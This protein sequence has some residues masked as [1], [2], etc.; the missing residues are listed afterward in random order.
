[1]TTVGIA[2]GGII[3]MSAAWRLVQAGLR[4]TVFEKSKIGMEASWA[5]AGMLSPGGEFEEDTPLARMAIESRDLYRAFVEE[6]QAES[7]VEIDFQ[8]AGALDVAYS[9]TEMDALAERAERQAKIG[10]PSKRVSAAHVATFWPRLN[11]E[12]LAGGYFYPGDAAVDP[13]Q[14]TAALRMVCE[15]HGVVVKERTEATSIALTNAGASINND[16]YNAVIIACGAW[17]GKLSIAGLPK[18]PDTQPIRGHLLGYPQPE[19]ICQGIVRRDHTYLLQRKNGFFLVGATTEDV[20]FDRTINPAQAAELERKAGFLMPHLQETMPAEI[21]N[22]LRP[23]SDELHLG[24]WHSD[25]VYLA[26][27]HHRNGILLAPAT[28]E[29]ITKDIRARF[30]GV[31]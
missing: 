17:S 23:N 14:V 24:W 31:L 22:G 25:L 26:Y 29:R 2:G 13:R 11:R 28:A 1:M 12:R 4:V 18:L 9:D 7:G 3:G 21:W 15:K 30:A 6:L 19:Q 27:G 10:I 8:E 20:G 16:V 5:A